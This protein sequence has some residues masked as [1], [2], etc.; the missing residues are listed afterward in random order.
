MQRRYAGIATLLVLAIG[1]ASAQSSREAQRKLERI[2]R[3]IKDVAS[4]RQQIAGQ[5]SDASRQLRSADVQLG[6][7]GRALNDTEVQL[8]RQQSSL[9]DLQQRR[10]LLQSTLGGQRQELAGLL[11]AAYA[12]PV[13]APLQLLLAQD[14]VADASRTL[15]LHRYLQRDRARR[16]AD[17]TSQLQA[18]DAVEQ[19]I[20]QTRSQ[21]AQTKVAQRMQL[22]QL[23][24]DRAAQVAAVAEL[25]QRYRD[26]A[27]REQALSRDARGLEQL[28]AQ[29]RAAAAREAQRKAAAARAARD[30]AS[31]ASSTPGPRMRPR[32]PAPVIANAAP[33]HVGGL[34]WPVTGTLLARF[35]GALPDGGTSQG[36][37]IA[38]SLGT[39]VKAVANG[40][41]VFADWMKGYGLILII[42]HGNGN[43]S[44]YAHNEALLR[45]VG[46]SIQRGDAVASVGNSGGQ[47]KPGLYFELRRNGQPVDPMGWLQRN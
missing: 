29:L 46:D 33:L 31:A 19:Q 2:Q 4:Q 45:D 35:G 37:L 28:L 24:R 39:P 18:L 32:P 27:D 16:I 10:Q 8:A 41:V 13:S 36:V 47:D 17:L 9:Q 21:L 5:R 1:C 15:T 23:Q 14:R 25:D 22:A 20:T 43:M 34:S 6:H 38:A 30:A 3:E 26:R 12:V 44:L 40:R 7:S 11:R 42:D